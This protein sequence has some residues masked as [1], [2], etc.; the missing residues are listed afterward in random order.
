MLA[1]SSS[2]IIPRAQPS[3]SC[4]PFQWN[5][6]CGGGMFNGV[7]EKWAETFFIICRI[8]WWMGVAGVLH[9]VGWYWIL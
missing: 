9:R 4:I 8:L 7:L 1:P 6:Y 2:L 5:T 3:N